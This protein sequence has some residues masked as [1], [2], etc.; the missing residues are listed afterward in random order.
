[1][2]CLLKEKL[3]PRPCLC[4]KRNRNPN[5]SFNP[6]EKDFGL[7]FVRI[8]SFGPKWQFFGFGLSCVFLNSLYLELHDFSTSSELMWQWNGQK[9]ILCAKSVRHWAQTNIFWGPLNHF[10]T[11][12]L[13]KPTI[14]HS[15]WRFYAL[16]ELQGW[17]QICW[18]VFLYQSSAPKV[19]R[20]HRKS[21]KTQNSPVP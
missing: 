3:V 18:A 21:R 14:F 16:S 1:M 4:C 5:R 10:I 15:I 6:N 11:R 13:L 20:T 2:F 19:H 7:V 9:P 12:F 8:R 17:A